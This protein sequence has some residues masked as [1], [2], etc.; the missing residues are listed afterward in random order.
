M[1][2][3]KKGGTEGTVRKVDIGENPKLLSF[4]TS[5]KRMLLFSAIGTLGMQVN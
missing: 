3:G 1:Q 2:K 4:K 5:H